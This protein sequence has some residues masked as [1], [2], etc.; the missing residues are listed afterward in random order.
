MAERFTPRSPAPGRPPPQRPLAIRL[1]RAHAPNRRIG[2]ARRRQD[3]GDEELR[4][5]AEPPHRRR[6]PPKACNSSPAATPSTF[7]ALTPQSHRPVESAAPAA[8]A[9][10]AGS[11]VLVIRPEWPLKTLLPCCISPS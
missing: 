5:P 6:P 3:P 8:A 1:R 9:V 10:R 7:R 2:A 4:G 11:P